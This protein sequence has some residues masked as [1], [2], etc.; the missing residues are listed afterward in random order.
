[1]ST[2]QGLSTRYPERFTRL[3]NCQEVPV[4]HAA[5]PDPP[6]APA[7]RRQRRAGRQYA[8]RD[9]S[10]GGTGAPSGTEADIHDGW[11][12]M[13][14]GLPD[15]DAVY[16]GEV[17][18]PGQ[19]QVPW[20]IGEP[21]PVIG[22]LIEAGRV[23]G[24]VLDAGCGVGETVLH[25]AARGY[26]AVG[27]DMSPTAVEQARRSAAE[28]GLDAEFA[29]ADITSF[30]GYDGRFDTV[31]DS[32][33]F[34]SMPVQGRSGYLSSIARAAAP[35]AVL[36]VL[37]FAKEAWFPG[38]RGP[39]SVDEPELRA[40]VEEY[41]A[42]ETVTHSTITAIVPPEMAERAGKDDRGRSL[43]PAYLLTAH[44]RD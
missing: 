11:D 39:N 1:M 7:G 16:G 29:V 22:V 41:W 31:I 38:D 23:R 14:T 13:S 27:L 34:H 6:T 5:P 25:L 30:T 33:L 8:G 17:V 42:V 44:R 4:A 9:L 32:T 19:E 10:A 15:F 35:G 18:M 24:E 2:G 12:A 36:H 43:L 21:Q 28:R 40:A 37:V 20:N 3:R 26:S